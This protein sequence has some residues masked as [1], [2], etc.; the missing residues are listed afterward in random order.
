MK[1]S[2]GGGPQGQLK[3]VSQMCKKA[4]KSMDYPGDKGK[5]SKEEANPGKKK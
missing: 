4:A 2:K 1:K 5:V 3:G